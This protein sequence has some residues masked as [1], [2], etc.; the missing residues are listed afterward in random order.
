MAQPHPRLFSSHAMSST[1]TDAAQPS[2]SASRPKRRFVGSKAGPKPGA[3]AQPVAH[4]IP[5]DILHDGALNAAIGALPAH[6]SFE[7]HKTVHHVR[8]HGA[9]MVA[10]QMPE[11]L[12]MFAC[13]IADIIERCAGER[14]APRRAR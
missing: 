1:S 11:G 14:A 13:A 7:L 5:A 3:P 6:Y 2:A 12:Q 4:Q 9:R 8:K 10:L